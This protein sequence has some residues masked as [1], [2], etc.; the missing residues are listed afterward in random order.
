MFMEVF[1][2]LFHK[3]WFNKFI[4]VINETK[5]IFCQMQSAL[6]ILDISILRE[7]VAPCTRF[8]QKS[9]QLCTLSQFRLCMTLQKQPQEDCF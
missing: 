4:L 2:I 7:K 9:T 5:D 3:N 8:T 6:V 1:M